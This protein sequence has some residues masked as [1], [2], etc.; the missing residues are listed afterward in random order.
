M[1]RERHSLQRLGQLL[2]PALRERSLPSSSDLP[3]A[4]W[5]LHLCGGLLLGSLWQR[6]LGQ[7]Y[8]NLSKRRLPRSWAELFRAGGMLCG[9]HLIESKPGQLL[10]LGPL[11]HLRVPAQLAID[12]QV[13]GN[14]ETTFPT[15]WLSAR[16]PHSGMWPRRTSTRSFEGT[17]TVSCPSKPCASNE[18]RGATMAEP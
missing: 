5:G 14:S 9:H 10:Q 16:Q 3:S 4:Q 11:L 6:S 8:G 13:S 15:Q 7:H 17:M 1:L 12:S 2:L 18:S